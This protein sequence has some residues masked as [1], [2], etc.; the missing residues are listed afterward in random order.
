MKWMK[1][2]LLSIALFVILG[3]LVSPFLFA[4]GIAEAPSVSAEGE[5]G[6]EEIVL[7]EWGI[8]FFGH[9]GEFIASGVPGA[10]FPEGPADSF[11]PNDAVVRAPVI[12]VNGPA[13]TGT[14]RVT[15]NGSI[16]ESYPPPSSEHFAPAMVEWRARF[17][18]DGGELSQPQFSELSTAGY[19]LW[20]DCEAMTID[21]PGGFRERFLYYEVIPY[22][23]GDIPVSIYHEI[24]DNF[25]KIPALAV[26]S[27]RG[28]RDGWTQV[29]R[30][31]FLGDIA[32]AASGSAMISLN[33][34]KLR[35]YL[36]KWAEG[37]L[38]QR[39]FAA[40]WNTW[41]D[42]FM[43]G[44]QFGG[45]E[46]YYDHG[47]VLYLLP[48]AETENISHIEVIQDDTNYPVRVNR[49]LLVAVPW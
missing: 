39:Q 42:W 2:V 47:Y 10:I 32:D 37:Y 27:G 30:S 48:A 21:V 1:P 5:T 19:Q 41:R 22:D 6:N 7:T 13:F 16:F 31:A 46:D 17:S 3:A 9:N 40:F 43:G 24:A 44:Y 12:Y 49:W 45:N 38:S 8:V 28:S 11:P 15:A 4:L 20:R 14:V 25:E 34:N 26:I 18:Y 29:M 23:L 35:T 36:E 33:E